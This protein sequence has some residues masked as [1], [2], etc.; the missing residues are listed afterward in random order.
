MY[1]ISDEFTEGEMWALVSALE[2]FMYD[3][4]NLTEEQYEL[5]ESAREKIMRDVI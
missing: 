5:C 4:P 2:L 3:N 1:V